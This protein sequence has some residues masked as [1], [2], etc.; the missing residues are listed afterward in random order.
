MAKTSPSPIISVANLSLVK[1]LEHSA[2]MESRSLSAGTCEFFFIFIFFSP[3]LPFSLGVNSARG[4][5]VV[6]R[7][8]I[9]GGKIWWHGE[10]RP[11]RVEYKMC[12]SIRRERRV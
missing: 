2:L 4:T 7:E 5:R 12:A 9:K 1:R 11:Y 10:R 8:C 3:S 6:G